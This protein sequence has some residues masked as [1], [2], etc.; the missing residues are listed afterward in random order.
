MAPGRVAVLG[1]GAWGTALAI[2][3]AQGDRPVWLWGRDGDQ[4]VD[5][6]ARRENRRHLPGRLLPSSLVATD[7]LAVAVRSA[8]L[9]LA[10]VPAQSLRGLLEAL[11]HLLE[12]GVP[13]VVCAKGIERASGRFMS[14][15]VR[16][17]LPANP[18]AILSGPSFAADV[19]LGLP[20]AVTI[21]AESLAEAARLGQQI[22]SPSFRLYHTDD[23]RGVEIGG[24]V[25]NV[26]AI[27][28]GIAEARGLGASAGAALIA[29]AF[30]EMS[31]FGQRAGGRAE[32]L[33]GLSGLGDLVLTC[34]SMQSR[35]F[36]FGHAIAF[37]PL[38]DFGRG[39]V[40]EGVWTA[41]ALAEL[42][43]ERRIDMPISSSVAAILAGT[44]RVDDAIDG[45]LSRPFRA[46]HR[47]GA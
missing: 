45:L 10:A 1:A 17:C 5:L 24:A 32:T 22:G 23:I 18:P 44:L 42:A 16:D 36:A 43:R 35:N 2:V 21:A 34:G 11:P 29:R 15:V 13:V 46:E 27:A 4:M 25:K 9:V 3:A 26:L 33:A 19:A 39:S 28:C 20:T 30:A 14:E 40:I 6:A 37:G 41:Q 12:R 31:R 8:D 38:P 7:D 47:L